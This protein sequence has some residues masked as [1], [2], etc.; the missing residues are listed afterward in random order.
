MKPRY[1]LPHNSLLA[2]LLTLTASFAHGGWAMDSADEGKGP[3]ANPQIERHLTIVRDGNGEGEGEE[4][5]MAQAAPGNLKRHLEIINHGEPGNMPDIDS[6]VSSAM[7]EAF[8]GMPGARDKQ[9]V[10][11]AP[12]SAEVI[13]EKLQMLPDGNQIS[14]R[15][16][17]LA[18]RDS[19]GR[20]RQEVRD[21]KGEV[22]SVQIHD[23][24]DGSRYVLL[25][26]KKTATKIKLDMAFARKMDGMKEKAE[27]MRKEGKTVIIE[28]SGPGEEAI[29]R[30]IESRAEGGK[31]EGREEIKINV[32][33]SG[34]EGRADVQ[35]IGADPGAMHLS[36]ADS[37]PGAPMGMM[38][39]DMK[40]SAKAISKDLGTRDFDGIRAEGKSRIYTIPAG[41]VGNKNPITVSNETWFSPELQ[42]TVYSKQSDPRS[43]DT[44]YRLANVK[45][46]EQP[47]ALFTVPA[48]YT[49]K[50]MPRPAVPGNPG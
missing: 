19:I 48:D 47:I 14:K 4:L 22:R 37:I 26:A 25:P 44:I 36:M 31:P 45:R 27:S 29:I 9:V 1:H 3:A 2:A 50:E 49:V 42:V 20:T 16:S 6:I 17:T 21:A 8:A 39:Q 46:N 33:R 23:A 35:I 12:Y 13:S 15:S 32:I 41:E 38:F 10:K 11:N 18:F 7:A 43:G 34:G 40:W 28:R 30:R 5:R 24:V